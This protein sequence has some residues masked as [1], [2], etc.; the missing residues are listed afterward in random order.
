MRL[1]EA[2]LSPNS[3]VS[4]LMATWLVMQGGGMGMCPNAG[5]TGR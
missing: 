3:K 5:L 4:S 1:G 2:K